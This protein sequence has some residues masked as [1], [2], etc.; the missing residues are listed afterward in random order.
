M[1]RVFKPKFGLNLLKDSNAIIIY[2]DLDAYWRVL[3]W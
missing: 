3:Q 2:R 1:A